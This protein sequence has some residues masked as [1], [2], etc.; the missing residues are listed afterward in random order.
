MSKKRDANWN[1]EGPPRKRR[2]TEGNH[3]TSLA[4]EVRSI[5][6]SWC[7]EVL[8]LGALARSL[9]PLLIAPLPLA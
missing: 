9:L 6:S 1:D 2:K 4:Q 5:L 8:N 3:R 7:H